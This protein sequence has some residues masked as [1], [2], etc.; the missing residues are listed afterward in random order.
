VGFLSVALIEIAVGVIMEQLDLGADE[1]RTYLL[2][3][4]RS[5]NRPAPDVA[6]DIVNHRPA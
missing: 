3:R 4:A 6:V 2:G 5:D 1:A